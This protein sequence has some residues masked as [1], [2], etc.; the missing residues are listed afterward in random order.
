MRAAIDTNILFDI[1]IPG[2]P[3]YKDSL[4]LLNR[5]AEK[6]VLV[7]NEL[8]Y[9][10]LSSQFRL[11]EELDHF[12][13]DTNIRLVP[14]GRE[15][16]A[17]AGRI[18]KSYTKNRHLHCTSCGNIIT[19]SCPGCGNPLIARQHILTDFIIGAF[20]LKQASLLI[21]RDRGFYRGYFNDLAIK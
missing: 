7:I 6:G 3:H 21:T 20:A 15:A 4:A 1:L 14:T 16:L 11:Q 10:E 19:L 5:A 17:Y 13:Q 8:I 9:A 12:L 2:A 18:W